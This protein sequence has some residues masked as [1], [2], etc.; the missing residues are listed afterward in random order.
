MN[1]SSLVLNN[2]Y[3][4]NSNNNITSNLNRGTNCAPLSIITNNKMTINNNSQKSLIINKKIPIIN[5]TKQFRNINLMVKNK[6]QKRII[7]EKLFPYKYYF[8]SV[9]IKNLDVSHK[10]KF[11]FSTKFSKIY[12]FMSKLFDISTYLTLQREFH[13]LKKI[14]KDTQI[15]SIEDNKKININPPGFIVKMNE[16]LDNN[17]FHILAL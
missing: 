11:F 12:I 10:K 2:N 7:R 4:R 8:Y 1:S 5:I 9:F 16:C 15:K 14:L 6:E 17:K 13:N 3:S